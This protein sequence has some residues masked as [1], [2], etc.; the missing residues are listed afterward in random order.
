MRIQFSLKKALNIRDAPITIFHGRLRL[1]ILF[2][3]FTSKLILILFADLLISKF[4]YLFT[5]LQQKNV[6]S[7]LKLEATTAF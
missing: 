4:I 6:C 5:L 2:Y 7:H 3:F 1:Q